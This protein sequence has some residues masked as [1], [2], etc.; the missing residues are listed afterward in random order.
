MSAGSWGGAGKAEAGGS[1]RL[2]TCRKHGRPGRV[3]LSTDPDPP[4]LG[5][6]PTLSGG[7]GGLTRGTV[8][9]TFTP[10]RSGDLVPEDRLLCLSGLEA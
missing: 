7:T 4:H 5:S 1:V 9:W 2:L 6:S 3:P 10:R 8:S